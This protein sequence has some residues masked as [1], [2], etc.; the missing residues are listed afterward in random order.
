MTPQTCWGFEIM[1]T[2]PPGTDTSHPASSSQSRRISPQIQI[3]LFA[4]DCSAFR[5]GEL[6]SQT[7]A[8]LPGPSAPLPC[9]GP[10]EEG[11]ESPTCL[12]LAHRALV[13]EERGC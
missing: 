11:W 9:A 5:E 6:L 2:P 12:P 7:A 3:S 1:A 8:L 13:P 10:H 4:E